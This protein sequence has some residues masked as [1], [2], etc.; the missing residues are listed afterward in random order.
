[1]EERRV[2]VFSPPADLLSSGFCENLR[3]GCAD[4]VGEQRSSLLG[5]ADGRQVRVGLAELGGTLYSC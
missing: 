5:E 1:M 4:S 2:F 3:D